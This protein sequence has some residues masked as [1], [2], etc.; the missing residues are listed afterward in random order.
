M[1]YENWKAT[2]R[3]YLQT[4]DLDSAKDILESGL[5]TFADGAAAHL[6]IGEVY[7]AVGCYAEALQHYDEAAQL[8][9]RDYEALLCGAALLSELGYYEE[10]EL[11]FSAVQTFDEDGGQSL[12]NQK[13]IP[14]GS[15]LEALRR[16]C[17][18]LRR[19]ACL[20]MERGS[21]D[22]ALTTAK[23]ALKL[24]DLAENRLLIARLH[25]AKG[26]PSR[27]LENLEHGRRLEPEQ[28]AFQIVAARCF[29]ALGDQKKAQ[30]ALQRA[31]LL[32]DQSLTGRALAADAKLW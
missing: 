6:F 13:L 2:I 7:V 15:S 32:G 1:N 19:I 3:G 22:Q 8:N 17:E 26:E 27:A 21:L 31:E 4:E 25:L 29:L 9:P 30:D 14:S 28:P 11:R 20:E 18:E 12:Y 24:L 5:S 10:A 16:E 23:K